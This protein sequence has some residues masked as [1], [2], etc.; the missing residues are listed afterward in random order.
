MLK[1]WVTSYDVERQG[2]TSQDVERCGQTSQD[3]E[4][5]G[6]TSQDVEKWGLCQ[7][8]VYWTHKINISILDILRQ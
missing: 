3:V 4:R 7:S 1:D 6:Q 5:Y 2:Q 8:L